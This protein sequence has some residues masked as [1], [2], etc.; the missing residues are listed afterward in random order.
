MFPYNPKPSN[1]STNV[2]H[3]EGKDVDR[4]LKLQR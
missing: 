2:S 4:S 1:V 3:T